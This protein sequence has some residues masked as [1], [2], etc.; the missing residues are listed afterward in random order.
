MGTLERHAFVLKMNTDLH[1][2]LDF[3]DQVVRPRGPWPTKS[4]TCLTEMG[5]CAWSTPIYRLPHS[6]D[7]PTLAVW[8]QKRRSSSA[9]TTDLYIVLEEMVVAIAIQRRRSFDPVEGPAKGFDLRGDQA[10]VSRISTI[11]TVSKCPMVFNPA[12]YELLSTPMRG[13]V[14]AGGGRAPVCFVS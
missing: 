10:D 12:S 1:P 2:S 8:N 9:G 11:R 3:Q 13:D 6:L 7:P 14:I 4:R 5:C